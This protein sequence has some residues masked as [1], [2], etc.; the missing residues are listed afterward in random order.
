PGGSGKTRLA[1]HVAG[2]L[3]PAFAHGAWLVS[4][5]GVSDAAQVPV[6]IIR[7]I[8]LMPSPDVLP[9]HSLTTYLRDK[10]LLLV[11]DNFEQVEE[12]ASVLGELLA[13]AP[14]LKILVTSRVV[15]HVYGEHEFSVPPLDIPNLNTLSNTS[16]LSEYSAIQ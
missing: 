7:A 1:L 11:L 13:A 8:G 6:S 15:L 5:A 4:L 14:A 2:N 16:Q 12:A 10:R 3:I 9:I